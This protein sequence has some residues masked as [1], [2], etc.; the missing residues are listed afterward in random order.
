MSD[1]AKT[2]PPT[3]FWII[4]AVALVWNIIGLVLYK[5][6]VTMPPEVLATFPQAQQDFFNSTPAWV[7][8][9]YGLAV[10]A[11]VLGS[12]FFLLRKAWAYPVFILSLVGVVVMDA[13]SYG[14]QNGAQIFE[15]VFIGVHAFVF[16]VAVALVWYSRKAKADGLLS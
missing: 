11:G 7:T 12:I 4:G 15:P 13:Y 16:L 14:V 1:A 6:Q 8:G 5:S 3:Y 9:F 2:K 10:T